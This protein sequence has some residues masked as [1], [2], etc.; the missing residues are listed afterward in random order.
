MPYD[1]GATNK[2]LV[3]TQL[4]YS[5]L[6][7]MQN[8]AW[9]ASDFYIIETFETLVEGYIK[10]LHIRKHN[11]ALINQQLAS[12]CLMVLTKPKNTT[13]FNPEFRRGRDKTFAA[14][15]KSYSKVLAE[16]VFL[17]TKNCQ[18]CLGVRRY[19]KNKRP[20]LNEF[21]YPGHQQSP[22]PQPQHHH[23]I[24]QPK[25]HGRPHA[26]HLQLTCNTSF[27]SV[28]RLEHGTIS[29]ISPIMGQSSSNFFGNS[30][31]HFA[32]SQAQQH[33]QRQQQHQRQLQQHHR[34]ALITHL[35]IS[36]SLSGSWSL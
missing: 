10:Q 3:Q 36:M 9:D 17:F 29:P 30:Q 13:I 33:H 26:H 18:T 24:Q 19:S 14:I 20:I 11:K 22:Q 27:T 5:Y 1:M 28:M 35:N 4:S 21:E 6:R 23:H 12:D 8:I 32:Y 16:L 34:T 31:L 7:I 2:F 25:H 15:T